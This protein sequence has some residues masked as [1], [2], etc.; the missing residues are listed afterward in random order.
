MIGCDRRPLGADTAGL[1]D[2][3]VD[4]EGAQL[5]AQ[6]I[7]Q[8]L[9]GILGGVVPAAQRCGQFPADGG[10]VD[11]GARALGAH[12][13]GHQLGEA[14]QAEDVTSNWRRASSIGTSSMAP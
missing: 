12:V 4:S 3:D 14:T 9:D 7:A 2:D 1:N 6:R 11:D 13:R 5:H 10:D 8:G